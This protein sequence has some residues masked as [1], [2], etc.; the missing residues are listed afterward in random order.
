MAK[1]N[2]VVSYWMD[3][4]APQRSRCAPMQRWQRQTPVGTAQLPSHLRED[5]HNDAP[6]CGFSSLVKGLGVD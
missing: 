2:D 3:L 6:G 1:G 5:S 4:E